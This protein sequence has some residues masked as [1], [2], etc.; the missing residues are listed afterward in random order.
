[1]NK[2]VSDLNRALKIHPFDSQARLF[3]GMTFQRSE[4]WTEALEDYDM[5]ISLNPEETAYL[6]R[7]VIKMHLEQ[8]H[9]ALEDARAALKLS[10][11]I[12]RC[13]ELIEEIEERMGI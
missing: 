4:K 7:A 6:N 5:A 8:Y 3:R 2:A 1:M 13:C 9:S 10:C 12:E 11:D